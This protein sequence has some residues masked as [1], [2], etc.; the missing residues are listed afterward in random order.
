MRSGYLII[1]TPVW[2]NAV[3]GVAATQAVIDPAPLWVTH[4]CRHTVSRAFLDFWS[5]SGWRDGGEEDVL[6]RRAPNVA[7]DPGVPGELPDIVHPVSRGWKSV[8]AVQGEDIETY[9]QLAQ[10]GRALD[11]PGF[12][13]S[14][15]QR[16]QQQRRKYGNYRDYNQQSIKVNAF[17][18]LRFERQPSRESDGLLPKLEDRISRSVTL[19]WPNCE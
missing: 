18:G 17:W 6:R 16:R 2:A 14:H 9:S 15:T 19:Q 13:A 12:V 7:V 1:R 3:H 10:L 4:Q 11:T 8:V 5:I